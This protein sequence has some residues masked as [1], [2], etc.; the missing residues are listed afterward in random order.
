ML[1]GVTLDVVI[2]HLEEE[3]FK[4]LMGRERGEEDFALEDRG[5]PK[6]ELQ[7]GML[8]KRFKN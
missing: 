2:H 1:Y 5:I 8:G 4:R 6:Y 7:R 3:E